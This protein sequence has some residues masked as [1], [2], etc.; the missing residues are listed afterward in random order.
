LVTVMALTLPALGWAQGK[1]KAAPS[2]RT[3]EVKVNYSGA[4]TG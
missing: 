3:L 4:G 1:S 2:D